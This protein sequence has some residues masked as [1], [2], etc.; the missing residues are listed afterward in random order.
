MVG[1]KGLIPLAW[2]GA[3]PHKNY[4]YAVGKAPRKKKTIMSGTYRSRRVRVRL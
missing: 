2:G 1:T 3:E 4:A